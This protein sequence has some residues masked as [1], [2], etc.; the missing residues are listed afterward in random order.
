MKKDRIKNLGKPP[1]IPAVCQGPYVP[2]MVSV[3]IPTYNRG[4]IIAST[5]ESV[6]AQTYK[7]VEIVVVDDGSKDDTREVLAKFGD[8]IRLIYQENAGLAAARNT[9][10]EAARGEFIA[11]ED[12]DDLWLP[13][14]LEAQ[15]ALMRRFPDMALNWTDMKA[16]SPEGNLVSERHLRT[17]YHVYNEIDLDESMPVA[18]KIND[19]VPDA[20]AELGDAVYREGDIFSAM[21]MGNLV[22]PPTALMRR[23]AIA[24]SGG[25][26]LTFA[27]TCEDYEFFWRVVREGRAGL[28]EAPG[29]LYRID[30]EDQLTRPDLHLFLAHGNLLALKR[31][32]SMDKNRIQ[33]PRAMIRKHLAAAYTWIGE[34][35]LFYGKGLRSAM[36]FIKGLTLNPIQQRA[37][38]LFPFAFAPN[39][40]IDFVRALKDVLFDF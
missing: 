16:V 6:L 35:E 38:T 1:M 28:V 8:S 14:K 27:W 21:Y 18:G 37:L 30:A 11:F 23:S 10:L 39:F 12:S 40:L 31:R 5:I 4:Y 34:E 20:P 9:G 36:Y 7:N 24:K 17:M 3:L 22:H 19:L 29:M 25:L 2:G 32:L 13:W 15:V 26:D 33:L